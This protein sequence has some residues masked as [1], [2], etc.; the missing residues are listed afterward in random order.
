MS[1]WDRWKLGAKALQLAGAVRDALRHIDGAALLAAVLKTVENEASD[2][3]PGQGTE[4]WNT[5][6][7]WFV[8]AFPQYASRIDALAAVIR[9]LVALLNAVGLFTSRKLNAS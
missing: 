4:K 6:A 7:D 2:P 3:R 1:L 8:A 5:L 9:A